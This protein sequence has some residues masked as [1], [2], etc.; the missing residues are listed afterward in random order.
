MNEYV[1]GIGACNVDIQGF[2]EK[3]VSHESNPGKISISCGGVT[4]NIVET[5]RHLGLN[6][7]LMSVYGNDHFSKILM[8]YHKKIGIDDS[9]TL[10]LESSSNLYLSIIERGDMVVALSD[11][12][13]LE[14]MS[15]SYLKDNIE[16]INNSRIIVADPCLNDECIN[17]LID[18]FSNKLAIDVVSIEK[19]KKLPQD[20]SGITIKTNSNEA[21]SMTNCKSE[22]E[23]A[24]KLIDRGA[25]TVL[26]TMG[27]H[28]SIVA[29]NGKIYRVKNREINP[30]C[31]T[32]AGDS[33]FAGF[34]Y[35][36]YMGYKIEDMI[37]HACACS[38]L[39]LT[40]ISGISSEIKSSKIEEVISTSEVS[41]KE[42]K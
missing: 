33:Y 20:L 26:I 36:K 22:V 28:G 4:R 25:I 29:E 16:L 8:D 15:V 31:V 6:I 34:L 18:N 19:A 37:R 11:M 38:E 3:A 7:K 23:A 1:L 13:P 32:G 12:T 39:S 9:P 24:R 40:S 10:R 2:T 17:Y 30:I 14:K 41:I 35:A 5:L 27:K 42:I 21:L